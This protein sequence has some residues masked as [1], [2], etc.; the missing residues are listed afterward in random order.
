MPG[1]ASKQAQRANARK[2]LQQER[3]RA[4]IAEL[5]AQRKLNSSIASSATLKATPTADKL[6]MTS[7][8]FASDQPASEGDP[9]RPRE[10]SFKQ[11]L[12]LQESAA[13]LTLSDRGRPTVKVPNYPLPELDTND[14]EEWASSFSR[15]LRMT[16]QTGISDRSKMDWVVS[17]ITDP[18]TL[19]LVNSVAKSESHW[20]EFVKKLRLLFPALETDTDLR[21]QLEEMTPLPE[22][23]SPGAIAQLVL[24]FRTI[25]TKL[26][27]GVLSQQDL[28]LRL[29]SKIPEKFWKRI[30]EQR[31]DRLRCSSFDDLAELMLEK[32]HEKVVEDH[33]ENHRR[34]LLNVK[35]NKV[36]L[37]EEE[38]Y[39]EELHA[40][41]R[42]GRGRGK[43][44]GKGGRGKDDRPPK[45]PRF[46]VTVECHYCRKPGHY[47]DSCYQRIY[48]ERREARKKANE[49][50]PKPSPK[51]KPAASPSPA[52]APTPA[53]KPGPP[54]RPIPP[55]RPKPPIPPPKPAQ[56]TPQ[57]DEGDAS[58][59]RKRQRVALLEQLNM[60]H[61][62]LRDL[63][64]GP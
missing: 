63:K 53:T 6:R 60:I 35:P 28:V 55:V 54:P 29:V 52:P 11:L 64:F 25:Y 56:E 50:N 38:Q 33:I 14:L 48:D 9:F 37:M 7:F 40:M 31:E 47:K 61:E 57:E 30:R 17:S 27:P 41:Q 26:T 24:D 2:R 43:G 39:Q 13:E 34:R 12:A 59:K 5:R 3:I 8:S 18:R 10:A 32:S 1:P 51:P 20:S 58:N 23:P 62:Q 22:E 44:K 4:R 15:W 46:S 49:A 19:K 16:G 42:G 36:R 21:T 45:E